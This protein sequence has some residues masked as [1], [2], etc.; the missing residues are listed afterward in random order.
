MW[1]EVAPVLMEKVRPRN[2]ILLSFTMSIMT[3]RR[4]SI[5]QAQVRR[6]AV[7]GLFRWV[8]GGVPEDREDFFLDIGH[9]F[10]FHALISFIPREWKAAKSAHNF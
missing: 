5:L 9:I 4:P 3:K 10:Y 1:T 7:S 2:H 6:M 8:S